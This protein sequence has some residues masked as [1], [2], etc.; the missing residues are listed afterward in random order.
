MSAFNERLREARIESSFSQRDMA[1]R[2]GITDRS[3]R[4]W[5]AGDAEPSI[6]AMVELADLFGVSLDWLCG[7]CL[8][9]TFEEHRRGLREHPRF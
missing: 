9:E 7:R 8:E 2:F 5:E 6:D 3:Y 1:A 4:R